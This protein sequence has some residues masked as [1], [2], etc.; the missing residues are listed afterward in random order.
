MTSPAR[1]TRTFTDEARAA[2]LARFDRARARTRRLFDLL[3][4]EAYYSRPIALRNPI[5]FYEGHIAAFAVNTLLKRGLAQPAIDVELER[6][7]AR[8]IDPE[9]ESKVDQSMS[10]PARD[11]VLAFVDEADRRLRSAIRDADLDVPGHPLLDRAEAAYAI[12]E[13]EEMH[14]ETLHYIWH[15]LDLDDKRPPV[16]PALEI[17]GGPPEARQI[18]VPPGRATLGVRRTEVPFAWDNEQ[19]RHTVD[20][21]AFTVDQHNV[22]NHDFMAFVEAGGYTN[23]DLWTPEGWAWLE[24]DDVKHP[25]F[26][27]REGGAWVWRAMFQRVP[28]PESWPV[29]VTQ[30][31]ATAYARW[32]QSRLMTEAE[33][34]RVAYG[35]PSGEE[36]TYPWGEEP[37]DDAR[38]RFGE[39]YDPVPAGA[40]PAGRSA[41]DVHDLSGNG[42]EWTSTPF[43]PFDGFR[44]MPS[45]PEYSADFFDNEH[46]VIKGASP[47][48]PTGT[49][50]PSFR[51][52]FR[53]RYPYVYATFRCVRA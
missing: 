22:T 40:R 2:L 49:L 45:Y 26:W 12:V 38:G 50:R 1:A 31:E 9:D 14:Q 10:W 17:D 30:A 47:A 11:T 21:E 41:W 18:A 43:A 51:N 8:G 35:T 16:R 20:V 32:R 33:F 53:P 24:R 13:H 27:E 15:R 39:H 52:W 29:Y 6:L 46:L 28:L 3:T 48:T 19:P 44:P 4:P 36:R 7:F 37:P 25:L 5:I 34:H 42:W 23:R